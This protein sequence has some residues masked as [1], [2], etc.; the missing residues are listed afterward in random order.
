LAALSSG[1]GEA[2]QKVQLRPSALSLQ[3]SAQN[4]ANEPHPLRPPPPMERLELGLASSPN[5]PEL[6]R[7]KL[8]G[9][10]GA[11]GEIAGVAD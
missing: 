7:P 9:A 5:A 4:R 1:F 11:S 3:P 8:E 2:T 6:W 10:I